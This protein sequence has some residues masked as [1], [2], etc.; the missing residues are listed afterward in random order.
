MSLQVWEGGVMS[1]RILVVDDEREM[2]EAIAAGLSPR[3][4]EIES[5]TSGEAALAALDTAEVDVVLTDL[6]MRGMDGLALCE[7]VVAN[8]PDL[9]VV[10]IPAFGS[11]ETAIAAI[12]AGAYDFITKPVKMDALAVALARAVQHRS[13]G[14]E[15]KRLRRLVGETQRF[16]ELMGDSPPMRKLHQLLDR[17]ADSDASV[18][19]TGESGTGKEVVAKALHRRGNRKDGPLVAINCAAMPE[20][21]LE[22]E[23]FR[24][25][26][27]AFT[28]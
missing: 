8:R 23:L 18:L 2:C 22:S 5:H 7:R 27:G 19:V 3:G 26:R 4:F 20:Q 28:A 25:V 15:L 9:P 24:H 16:E 11:L 21:L 10:V 14:E 6:N 12:R 1:G 17:V 13:L